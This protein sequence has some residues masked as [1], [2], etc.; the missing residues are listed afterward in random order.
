MGKIIKWY[1]F[2]N[3][4]YTNEVISRELPSENAHAEVMCDD[5]K[6]R[7]LWLCSGQFVTKVLKNKKKQN[8]DFCIYKKEGKY[9]KVKK[10][11]FLKR[12]K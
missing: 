2:T 11:N 8:L 9:G 1:V 5:G 4:S 6:E 7:S 3:D 10:A 12:K